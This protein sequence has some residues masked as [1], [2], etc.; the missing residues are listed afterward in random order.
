M[1]KFICRPFDFKNDKEAF[2]SFMR[3]RG[4]HSDVSF[5]FYPPTGCMV[6]FDGKPVCAGFMIRC[7]NNT[8]INTD[9]ISDPSALP[10]VRS[11]AVVRLREY[12]RGKAEAFGIPFIIAH[13]SHPGLK[14]KLISQ[15]YKILNEN[16]THLGRPSWL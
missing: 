6:E 9:I 16:I 2:T 11:E 7:D 1:S 12:L 15:G 5:E 8:C 14:A 13:A 3:K 4:D 10:Q